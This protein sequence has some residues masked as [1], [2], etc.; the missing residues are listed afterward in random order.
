MKER[1][2]HNYIEKSFCDYE[3]SHEV[4]FFRKRI[5]FTYLDENN[6]IH[7]IELKI[8]DWRTALYQIETNQL[9]ANYCYLGIWHEYKEL[10]SKEI[11]EKYGFGLLSIE[12]EKCELIIHPKESPILNKK[13]HILVKKQIKGD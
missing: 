6:D 12:K 2:M 8:K 13:Y 1:L 10:V 7:A 11:L 3:F 5:D 4:K 9:C